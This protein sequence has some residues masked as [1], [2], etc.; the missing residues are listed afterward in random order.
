MIE[1]NP[2]LMSDAEVKEAVRE[3]AMQ[4]HA[5]QID[6]V[7]GRL[8]LRLHPLPR[9]FKSEAQAIR[10]LPNYARHA[11]TESARKLGPGAD[12]AVRALITRAGR[13][14]D[15]LDYR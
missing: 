9:L 10:E 8:E 3:I 14:Q 12:F 11:F 2:F 4:R 13:E 5:D 7:A 1:K 6:R 15:C